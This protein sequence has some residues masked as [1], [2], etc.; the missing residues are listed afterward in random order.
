MKELS[1]SVNISASPDKVWSIL[2][3]FDKYPEWNPFII[4]IIGKVKLRERLK[5]TIQQPGAKPMVFKP[6]VTLFKKEKQFGWLGSLFMRGIFDGHHIFEIEDHGDGTCTFVQREE[7]AGVLVPFLWKS[8]DIKTRA[9]FE[10]MN[11]TLK[12]LAER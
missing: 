6:Q 10:A 8:L 1:T 2:M 12:S 4:S 11:N 5:I 9:G 3:D 7:F